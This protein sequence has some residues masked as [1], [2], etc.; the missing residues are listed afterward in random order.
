MLEN[1]LLSGPAAAQPAD[2]VVL[3]IM[4]RENI[5]S[6]TDG[7]NVRNRLLLMSAQNAINSGM[8]TPTEYPT[9]YDNELRDL[10]DSV[11]VE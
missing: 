4:D 9:D 5:Q 3:P 6:S 11:S 2:D 1:I 10:I 7:D 8:M